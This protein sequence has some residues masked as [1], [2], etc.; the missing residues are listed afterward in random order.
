MS[1]TIEIRDVKYR[2]TRRQGRVSEGRR[3]VGQHVR[4]VVGESVTLHGLDYEG[5]YERVRDSFVPFHEVVFV[6]PKRSVKTRK[7]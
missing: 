7:Q 4:I 5:A 1:R 3:A 6:K 2:D